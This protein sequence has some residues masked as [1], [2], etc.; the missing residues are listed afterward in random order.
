MTKF[1]TVSREKLLAGMDERLLTQSEMESWVAVRLLGIE[2][3]QGII[4]EVKEIEEVDEAKER[5]RK[6]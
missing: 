5:I 2:R 6:G 1:W 4:R 3:L